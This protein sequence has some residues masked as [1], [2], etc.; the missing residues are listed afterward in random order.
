MDV[1]HRM[2]RLPEVLRLTG[3]GKSTLYEMISDDRFP[4]Q[5]KIGERARGWRSRDIASWL[6]S[7][8]PTDSSQESD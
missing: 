4:R 3:L 7:R 2:M 5:V 1:D 8:P 6:E